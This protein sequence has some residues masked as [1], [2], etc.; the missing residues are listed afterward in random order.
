MQTGKQIKKKQRMIQE[1]AKLPI[2]IKNQASLL[3]KNKKKR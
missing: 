3:D 2:T 1:L